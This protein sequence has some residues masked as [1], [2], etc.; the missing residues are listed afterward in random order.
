M[1]VIERG[2]YP[3]AIPFAADW[4]KPFHT[5]GNPVGRSEFHTHLRSQIGEEISFGCG[6][7]AVTLAVVEH[8]GEVDVPGRLQGA[9]I[10]RTKQQRYYQ[11]RFEDIFHSQGILTGL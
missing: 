3:V 9:D 8:R 11:R 4:L 10:Q 6:D 1:A 5:A 2:A 7:V